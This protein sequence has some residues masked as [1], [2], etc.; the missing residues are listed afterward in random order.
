M[1]LE[2]TEEKFKSNKDLKLSKDCTGFIAFWLNGVRHRADGPAVIYDNGERD[3]YFL[4]KLVTP[5]E[6]T[7]LSHTEVIYDQV[8]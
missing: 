4:G 7:R 8:V 5:E 1:L 6:F 3:F 2:D